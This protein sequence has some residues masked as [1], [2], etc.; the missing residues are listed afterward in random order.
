MKFFILSLVL[1]AASSAEPTPF[2]AEDITA[3]LKA[4][5]QDKVNFSGDF[6]VSLSTPKITVPH[7]S[8]E[9]TLALDNIKLSQD[10]KSVQATLLL[11]GPNGQMQIKSLS[12]K[13]SPLSEIPILSRV[14]TPGDIIT[15]ADI[16]WQ[17]LPSSRLSQNYVMRQE[18]LIGLT[19]RNRVIQ[20]GQP[21]SRYDVRA[22]IVIKR[23]DAVTIAYRTDNMLLTTTGIAERDAATGEFARFKTTNSNRVIQAKV[24]GPQ[25][26]EINRVEF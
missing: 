10:Q 13:I 21:I 12:G 9:D 4:Q 18:D 26:A 11:V 6:N 1:I 17:K 14:I 5:L 16:S 22:P 3:L 8:E 7:D 20:P 25:K 24:I 19:S 15:E 2:S 23:G